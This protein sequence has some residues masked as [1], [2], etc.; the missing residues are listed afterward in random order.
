MLRIATLCFSVVLYL[1]WFSSAFGQC[2]MSIF[3]VM[4]HGQS[5]PPG[6]TATVSLDHQAQPGTDYVLHRNGL[7][8]DNNGSAFQMLSGSS[9]PTIQWSVTEPGTY[10]VKAYQGG[11]EQEM[12][13]Q[14]QVTA[15]NS[16]DCGGPAL[17]DPELCL[18]ISSPQTIRISGGLAWGEYQLKKDGVNEGTPVY[19]YFDDCRDLITWDVSQ[20]GRYTVEGPSGCGVQGFTDVEADCTPPVCTERSTIVGAPTGPFTVC[21]GNLTLSSSDGRAGTWY[22]IPL[23]GSDADRQIVSGSA[24]VTVSQS[25]TYILRTTSCGVPFEDATRELEFQPQIVNFS[26]TGTQPRAAKVSA[27][28]SILPR[29]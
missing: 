22:R 20:P 17:E 8:T 19:Y 5:I 4:P 27:P 10:T 13:G 15:N 6:G 29:E 7:P 12:L 21:E 3:E 23:G 2:Q 26:L 18:S 9:N 16:C 14:A 11:C 1:G 24:Q 25:G 28:R